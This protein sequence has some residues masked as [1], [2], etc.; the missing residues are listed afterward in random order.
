M[1]RIILISSLAFGLSAC[2]QSGTEPPKV[3]QKDNWD[4]RITLSAEPGYQDDLDVYL[5]PRGQIDLECRAWSAQGKCTFGTQYYYDSMGTWLR[6]AQFDNGDA[7]VLGLPI[8]YEYSANGEILFVREFMPGKKQPYRISEYKYDGSN[9]VSSIRRYNDFVGGYVT[10]DWTF[11]Y[12]SDGRLD[13]LFFDDHLFTNTTNRYE[14]DAAGKL[15][16]VTYLYG[17]TTLYERDDL[18]RI[19]KITSTQPG[20]T[21]TFDYPVIYKD[22]TVRYEP[23]PFWGFFA[24]SFFFI[25]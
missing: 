20:S 25:H 21:Q 18:G 1:R 15:K 4:F 10:G 7:P 2:L 24:G 3:S 11:G 19:V 23:D 5:N 16:K 22:L 13:T 9:H 14:Y 8:Q 12:D 6:S 17:Y